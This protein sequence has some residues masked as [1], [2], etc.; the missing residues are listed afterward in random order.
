MLRYDGARMRSPPG[1][2]GLSLLCSLGAC[3]GGGSEP[4]VGSST[5][6]GVD[7][8]TVA[9]ADL[10]TTGMDTSSTGTTTSGATSV[11]STT[12]EPTT[13]PMTG[14]PTGDLPAGACREEEDC[15]G[16]GE[17]CFTPDRPNCGDCRAPQAPCARDRACG[18]DEVCVPFTA[19]C[20]CEPGAG[21]CVPRCDDDCGAD[22]VCDEATGKCQPLT[23]SEDG[24]ECPPHFDCVPGSGGSDCLRRVCDAD[25][26]CEGSPCVLGHCFDDFGSCAPPAP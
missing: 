4:T 20:A 8:S 23:C 10:V 19:P 9:T 15:V 24:V 25:D 5:S 13:T 1:I 16:P 17:S 14:D 2:L 7:A 3:G 6:T 18:D 21:Q 12:L 26:E 22:A 11:G